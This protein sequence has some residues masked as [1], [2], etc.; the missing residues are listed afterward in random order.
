VFLLPVPMPP[1][2]LP[3]P[4]TNLG[5]NE[6]ITCNIFFCSFHNIRA[7]SYGLITLKIC[8][9]KVPSDHGILGCKPTVISLIEVT[10]ENSWLRSFKYLP[11]HLEVVKV[12]RQ[13]KV[14]GLTKLTPNHTKFLE[15][16]HLNAEFV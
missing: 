1:S 4:S 15:R 3:H 5:S 10:V 11:C 2:P 12:T 16:N 13:N 14:V 9:I 7:R 6:E 8:N